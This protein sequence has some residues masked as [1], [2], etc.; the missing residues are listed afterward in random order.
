MEDAIKVLLAEDSP[1]DVE[2]IEEELQQMRLHY[3]LQTVSR[4]AAYEASLKDFSPDLILSNYS[5]PDF[6][7]LT[8]LR[9]AQQWVPG[10]PVIIVTR[11]LTELIAVDCLK[12][13]A[14]DYVIKEHLERL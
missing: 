1:Q 14:L 3:R 2:L 8:A 11:S 13:G 4:R 6:D 7:G 5:L 12:A 10:T 9:L